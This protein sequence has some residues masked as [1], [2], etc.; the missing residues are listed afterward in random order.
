MLRFK[1]Y[2]DLQ[3][4]Y[5]ISLD[6]DSDI[7]SFKT[8]IDKKVLKD[9]L[10]IIK[11]S[12]YKSIAFAGDEKGNI[13]VRGGISV[14]DLDLFRKKHNIIKAKLKDGKGSLGGKNKK[15]NISGADWEQIITASYNIKSK[16]VNLKDAI[17]MGGMQN[18]W[19]DKFDSHIEVGTK[20][21]D[22]AFK[23]T[24]N[25]MDHFG[26]KSVNLNPEWDKH[27]IE[28][29][30]K[31]ATAPTKTPKT[32][33][34]IGD[35]HI[36][37]KKV[38]GSQFMSGGKAETLATLN[39]AYKNTSMKVKTQKLDKAFN[40]LVSDI[41][42]G[43]ESVALEPGQNI[44]TIKNDLKTGKKSKFLDKVSETISNNKE[45]TKSLNSLFQT[46]EIKEAVVKE[47]MTGENKFSDKLASANYMLVFD[48]DGSAS[49]KE[50]NDSIV[51]KYAK[52]VDF[53]V[54][55]KTGST[56]GSAQSVLRGRIS[57]DLIIEAFEEAEKEFLTEGIFDKIKGVSN[58]ILSSIKSFVLKWITKIVEKIKDLV[59]KGLHYFKTLLG[60]TI[61]VN[62]PKI[63]YVI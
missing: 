34:Y 10:S 62:N 45:L 29:T 3:E 28:M 59:Y 49:Y 41:V 2:L 35:Q 13:K 56:G 33:M 31:S 20:I 15:S 60:I 57:E 51:K 48:D 12:N 63:R 36:S 39:F 8:D 21:V 53:S 19:L 61:K 7:E 38:G 27:F 24:S 25:K 52:A 30:G 4:A 46:S 42:K 54:S 50:I 6:S 17:K 40:S 44:T 9:L 32:D 18:S 23:R 1:Q 22:N 14:Q 37:L 58:K 26:A 5:D 47:A 43:F 11:K 16:N 55:F